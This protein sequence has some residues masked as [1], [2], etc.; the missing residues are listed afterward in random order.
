MG[1]GLQP[2]ASSDPLATRKS[3]ACTA[4][5]LQWEMTVWGGGR[6]WST[7]PLAFCDL[8][9]VFALHTRTLESPDFQLC[10]SGALAQVSSLLLSRPLLKKVTLAPDHVIIVAL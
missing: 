5:A 3:P 4:P 1:E 7:G 9:T 6:Q 2:S 8:S 10:P